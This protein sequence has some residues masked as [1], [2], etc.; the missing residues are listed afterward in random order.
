MSVNVGYMSFISNRYQTKKN[1][2]VVNWQ[3]IL[4]I[5]KSIHFLTQKSKTNCFNFGN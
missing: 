5:I 4:N 3:L 2:T 1:T